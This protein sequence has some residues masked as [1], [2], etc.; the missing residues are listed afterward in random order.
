MGNPLPFLQ[1]DQQPGVLSEH[2]SDSKENHGLIAVAHDLLKALESKD[3]K[4]VANALSN[5]FELLDSMPHDEGP[6][7]GNE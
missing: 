4:G 6:H 2:R 7:E 1:Q 5:A 3:I